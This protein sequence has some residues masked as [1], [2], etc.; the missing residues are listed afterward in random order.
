MRLD[1]KQ[2]NTKSKYT[3]YSLHQYCQINQLAVRHELVIDEAAARSAAA[4]KLTP[5]IY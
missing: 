2:A 3:K 1:I 5:F 4:D